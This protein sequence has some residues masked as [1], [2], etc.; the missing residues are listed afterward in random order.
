VEQ[1]TLTA[2]NMNTLPQVKLRKSWVA[3]AQ[4]VIIFTA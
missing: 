1:Q 4:R 2:T 3:Q